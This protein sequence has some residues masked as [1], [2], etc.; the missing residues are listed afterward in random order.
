MLRKRTFQEYLNSRGKVAE[1]P[2]VD[3]TADTGPTP[4]AKPDQGKG[5]KPYAP[6]KTMKP[7]GPTGGFAE[8]GAGNLKYAPGVTG[9]DKAGEG[10]KKLPSY[11]NVRSATP[12]SEAFHDATKGMNAAEFNQYIAA[13]NKAGGESSAH[14]IQYVKYTTALMAENASVATSL[15]HE[16]K[17][18]NVR[19]L[20]VYEA[21]Q[22]P[23]AVKTLVEMMAD[24]VIG[25]AFTRR[26]AR[27]LSE[28]VSPPI[29]QATLGL[30]DPN[31]GDP[32]AG[33]PNA[34]PGDVEDGQV[35]PN[36]PP[37]ETD[38]ANPEVDEDGNPID[39]AAVHPSH[40]E[41]EEL[42]PNAV[43]Q[44]APGLPPGGMMP[45]MMPPAAENMLNALA[46]HARLLEGMYNTV[47]RR[48][49][50]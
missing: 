16:A 34:V 4:T 20:L 30:D 42:D 44:G 36:A 19:D 38:P 12:K 24:P 9:V 45:G 2:T 43:P 40:G 31:A 46:G 35:D 7:K 47:A 48:V 17:R 1:K 32:N 50:R 41:G 25:P 15:I 33:D 29:D 13:Q 10:G 28:E 27:R 5:S 3:A 6:G 49:R 8:K 21:L 39:P 14:P 11:P 37:P 26:L 18:R 22:H 23:E